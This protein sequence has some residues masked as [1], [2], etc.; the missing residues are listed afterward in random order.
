MNHLPLCATRRRILPASSRRDGLMPH[1]LLRAT[2]M[3]GTMA[4]NATTSPEPIVCSA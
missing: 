3:T 2:I 1:R 4:M